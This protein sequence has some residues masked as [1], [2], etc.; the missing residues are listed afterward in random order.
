M[1]CNQMS[2]VKVYRFNSNQKF[3]FYVHL[4]AHHHG[5]C[6][7]IDYGIVPCAAT[8]AILANQIRTYSAIVFIIGYQNRLI[9]DKIIQRQP[10]PLRPAAAYFMR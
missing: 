1:L 10:G 6:T 4:H 5:I 2:K 9:V 8:L 7:A 3:I